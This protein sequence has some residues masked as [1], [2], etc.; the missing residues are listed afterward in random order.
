MRFGWPRRGCALTSATLLVAALGGVVR[1]GDGGGAD[2]APKPF[3][4][5][6]V[7]FFEERVRPILQARCLKCH[8]G[9]PKIRGGFRLDSR[10]AVLKGGDL[11]SAV[12]LDQ[13]ERSLLLQ[14]I[15]Y[16]E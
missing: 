3:R 6:Q 15:R 12:A 10:A 13:P 8:G 4:A 9:G 14:A 7:R 5:E 1:A 11:G 2:P 16:E